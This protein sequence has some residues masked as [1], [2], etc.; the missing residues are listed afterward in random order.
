VARD[1]NRNIDAAFQTTVLAMKDG[2]V[3]TGLYRRNEP[4]ALVFADKEGKEFSVQPD[5]I[6]EQQKVPTSLMSDNVGVQ[7]E[8]AMFYDLISYLMSLRA[9][10]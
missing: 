3:V 2:R 7:M 9:S 5:E 6:D 8:L 4:Q 10:K 1:P